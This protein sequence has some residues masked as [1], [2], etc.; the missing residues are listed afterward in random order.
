MSE[1]AG[2][3]VVRDVAKWEWSELWSKEDWWAVWLGFAI[4]LLGMILYFPT[5]NYQS[6][7][8]HYP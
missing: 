7:P 1:G 4:L 3:D 6:Y 5:S 2:S 8:I